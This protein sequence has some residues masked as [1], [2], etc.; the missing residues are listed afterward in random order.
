MALIAHS[1][2]RYLINA[3]FAMIMEIEMTITR[4]VWLNF[5]HVAMK[6]NST[7]VTVKRQ[8]WKIRCFV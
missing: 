1:V 2:F 3:A 4:S 7:L 8:L 6:I 5:K